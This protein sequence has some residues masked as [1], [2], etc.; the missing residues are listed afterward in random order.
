MTI[1]F[2]DILRGYAVHHL[3]LRRILDK[4]TWNA[5]RS[6]S[7]ARQTTSSM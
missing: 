5:R 2:D 3:L 4:V 6:L 1:V 7:S